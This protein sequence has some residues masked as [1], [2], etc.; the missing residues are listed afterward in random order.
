MAAMNKISPTA[1]K[2][3]VRRAEEFGTRDR[4]AAKLY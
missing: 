3:K 1:K 2:A 4:A